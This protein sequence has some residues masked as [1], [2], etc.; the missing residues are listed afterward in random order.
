MPGRGFDVVLIPGVTGGV[1]SVLLR[2]QREQASPKG[3][4]WGG[5]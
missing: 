2:A 3:T 4:R 5:G 1:K